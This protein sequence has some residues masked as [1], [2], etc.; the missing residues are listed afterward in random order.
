[1]RPG[2]QLVNVI[3]DDNSIKVAEGVFEAGLDSAIDDGV[4]RDFPVIG[5]V[6]ALGKAFGSYRD[7]R[8]GK[9]VVHFLQEVSKLS[10]SERAR[11]VDEI[12]G[13]DAKKE[14]L[15]DV[16]I[17]LLDKVDAEEKA[18]I[19]GKLFVGVG[20]GEIVAKDYVRLATMV[21]GVFME[22]L[23]AI[24]PGRSALAASQERR[25]ALQAHGFL[26]FNIRNPVK[27]LADEF[28]GINFS[29]GGSQDGPLEF[30]WAISE[31]GRMIL[32]YC[33]PPT[34]ISELQDKLRRAFKT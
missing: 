16:L 6:V 15:G 22:D 24:G 32:N 1:M 30:E 10:W 33:F 8:L 9:K 26:V 34:R 4:L 13:S 23:R 11:V 25:F 2:K 20:R 21:A 14:Q 7:Y 17:D 5:T 28:S 18:E 19:L 12:A 31:D 27:K 29:G 3:S